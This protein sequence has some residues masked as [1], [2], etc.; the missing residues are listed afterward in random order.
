MAKLKYYGEATNTWE[1][2]RDP[3]VVG[4]YILLRDEHDEEAAKELKLTEKTGRCLKDEAEAR[5][6]HGKIEKRANI[7]RQYASKGKEPP[8][9][10]TS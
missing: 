7:R 1:D 10:E 8:A 3:S 6:I 2:P 9:L 5:D 4:W